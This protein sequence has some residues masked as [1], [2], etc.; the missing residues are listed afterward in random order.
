MTKHQLLTGLFLG[1]SSL[2]YAGLTKSPAPL[3]ESIAEWQKAGFRAP[4][5][6]ASITGVSA[7]STIALPD[8]TIWYYTSDYTW[9]VPENPVWDGDRTIT[10]FRFNFYDGDLNPV[11]TVEDDVI[12]REDETRVAGLTLTPYITRKFFNYDDKYEVM[13]SVAMNTPRY[14]NRNYT[15]V[16]AIDDNAGNSPMIWELED[17]L[18]GDA[19]NASDNEWTESYYVTFM[20]EYDDP[21]I[22]DSRESYMLECV[23][24]KKAGYSD[25]PLPV[26]TARIPLTH[27]PGDMEQTSPLI[28]WNAG[29]KAYFLFQQ[30]DK[31]F[32]TE[33]SGGSDDESLMPDNSLLVDIYSIGGL[34]DDF[35]AEKH[36]AIPSEQ[37]PNF[38]AVFYGIGNLGFREDIIPNG[39]DW[40][41]ILT[42]FYYD[43]A[44]DEMINSYHHID[45]NGNYLNVIYEFIDPQGIVRMRDIHGFPVQ[46]MFGSP[47]GEMDD[48]GNSYYEYRAVN[49]P[50]GEVMFTIPATLGDLTISTRMNRLKSGN[51][52]KYAFL[53]KRLISADETNVLAPV[54][55]FDANGNHTSTD[56]IPLGSKVEY[57]DASFSDDVFSPYLFNTDTTMEYLF[58]VKRGDGTGLVTDE[59]LVVNENG[60]TLLS[61]TN[62]P[63]MGE[64][65]LATVINNSNGKK[66]Q[67]AYLDDDNLVSSIFF[68]L[69]LVG[70]ERIGSG[71]EADPYIINSVADLA[72]IGA[73][74]DAY[75]RVESDFDASGYDFSP[76]TPDFTGT[77]DGNNHVISN[78]YI[79]ASEYNS[80]IFSR[81]DGATVKDL[82]LHNVDIELLPTTGVCGTLAGNATETTV[83]NF[84]IDGLTV[85]GNPTPFGGIIGDA[86]MHSSITSC[87]V[88]NA[89]IDDLS[90]PVGGLLSS[91]RTAC[92]INASLFAGVIN[93]GTEVGGIVGNAA[94]GDET[95]TNCHVDASLT[96]RNVVG[97]IIGYSNRTP[98]TN[99]FV[100]GEITT[101]GNPQN[102][103]DEGPCAGGVIGTLMPTF[104]EETP[105][106]VK[107]NIVALSKMTGAEPSKPENYDGQQDTLHR[108]VGKSSA[109]QSP[110]SDS[111]VKAEAGLEDNYFVVE[112]LSN[113]L[114][115]SDAKS[116][117]GAE[118]TWEQLTAERLEELGWIFGNDANKPWKFNNNDQLALY[119]EAE[120]S[121]VDNITTDNGEFR[122]N[123]N[124]IIAP[125]AS[126]TVYTLS[127]VK[128]AE[129]ANTVNLNELPIGLYI[130]TDGRNAIKIRR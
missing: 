78:L 47:T 21:E 22:S 14:I 32:F 113:D 49:V 18:C 71:T 16:Y 31:R 93:A 9:D 91:I 83:S 44:S 25:G 94:S 43:V 105:V 28:S 20:R 81:L 129:S 97:G 126:L 66:L 19:V 80:G 108:I 101:L 50:S 127:G 92:T 55:W 23:T 79:V 117:E 124:I 62:D 109:N 85:S 10:H 7:I 5:A 121:G 48:E 53:T 39:N 2:A 88:I 15:R 76:I 112:I 96:A 70:Q 104:A 68:D 77:L 82:T 125:G 35:T 73:S 36:L 52:Y 120:P 33:P 114:A 56:N 24:Y 59:Y 38:P 13:V 6:S 64:P 45:G 123:G 30:Y 8:G 37:D 106:I 17:Y 116:V 54:V 89:D 87:S 63:V 119:Y 60:E 46:Y 98:V 86:S 130:V 51:T 58:L 42:K 75:F 90:G 12:H 72:A 99:C 27:Y 67:I 111:A 103:G 11:G 1:L 118:M 65:K 29:G 26:N 100:E 110:A 95:I 102:W 107:G 34:L 61:C 84:H 4:E 74:P 122:V 115:Y 3:H 69:P 40:N 41:F 57:W 128:V